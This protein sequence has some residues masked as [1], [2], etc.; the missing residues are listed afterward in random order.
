MSTPSN[1]VAKPTA[2]SILTALAATNGYV[3]LALQLGEVVV[4]LG[5]ALVS[6]I[7]SLRQ[8]NATI[9]FQL[10]VAG[11]QAELSDVDKL[12]TDDL[13]AINVELTRLGVP[14]LPVPAA[15]G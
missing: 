10:L 7:E 12:S 5:K 1:P 8:G 15:G 14:T 11:D 6:K 9:D 2:S 3:S 4:P 13:T